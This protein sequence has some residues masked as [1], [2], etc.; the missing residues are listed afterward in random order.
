[1][2]VRR[3]FVILAG[4]LA[5]FLVVAPVQAQTAQVVGG[6]VGQFT[7]PNSGTV[8]RIKYSFMPNGTFQ[9]SFAM[10]AGLAGG[11]DWVAG[12]WFTE[13]QWLRLEVKQHYSSATG[14]SGPM[15]GGELWFVRMPNANVM[16]LTHALC[17][18]QNLNRPD[19]VLQLMRGQ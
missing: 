13:G 15:P 7:D 2:R 14:N 19:C 11:Y 16:V 4:V 12:F 1:M 9:K 6:W 3:L 17:V 8:M 10:Q 5:V 18:Q